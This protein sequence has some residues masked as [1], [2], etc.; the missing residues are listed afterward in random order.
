MAP[1]RGTIVILHKTVKQLSWRRSQL[2]HFPPMLYVKKNIESIDHDSKRSVPISPRISFS[3]VELFPYCHP[4]RRLLASWIE[5]VRQEI[6]P[7]K[8]VCWAS[9]SSA[10]FSIYHH[11]YYR[12]WL[13]CLFPSGR[14]AFVCAWWHDSAHEIFFFTH[15]HCKRVSGSISF[16]SAIDNSTAQFPFPCGKIISHFVYRIK[17]PA[18]IGSRT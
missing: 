2:L 5:S 18:D 10:P 12:H 17:S 15:K 13:G 11:H 1:D 14:I 7:A 3:I 16:S 9:F 4:T 8:I 6:E